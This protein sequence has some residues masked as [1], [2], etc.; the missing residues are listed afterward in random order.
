MKK[1]KKVYLDNAAS[2]PVAPEVLAAM[3]PFFTEKYGNASSLH[4]FGQDAKNTLE[5]ARRTVAKMINAEPD[6][7][8]FTSGGSESNNLALKGIAT[9][10]GHIITSAVE[11]PAVLKPCEFLNKSLGCEITILPVDKEGFVSVEDVKKAIKENTLLVS[12]MHAN[13]EVGVIQSIA[14]I[15]NICREKNIIFHTDA[16]QS[17]G[18]IKIDAKAM[19][20]DMLSA[21]SH[22]INGPK[23]V[24]V[25]Y[26]RGGIRNRIMPQ[27]HGGSQELGIRAGTENVAGVVGFAKACELAKIDDKSIIKLRNKLIKGVLKIE[28]SW[29]N[30]PRG[31]NLDK[32]LGNNANFSFKYIEGEALVL[33]L[34]ALGIAG[35]TGSAC[36]SKS[37]KPSHVLSAL[38]LRPEDA[39]GSL[40]LTLGK[41]TEEED[42]DYVLNILPGVVKELRS[43]SPFTKQNKGE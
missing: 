36:S 31:K 41:Y 10:Q 15:G 1:I 28:D 29:L 18:K 6:E 33:R 21:S 20:V 12:I 16:V 38:G 22:K 3:K 5:N 39:H 23:G 9:K 27:I 11:H 2:T 32:R 17:F 43:I 25:L 24:G 19:N 7:I 4:S 34:D 40:R 13:N 35:S 14:D 26:I 8:F 42:I 30:G 37:L